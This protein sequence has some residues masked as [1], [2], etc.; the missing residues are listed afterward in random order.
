M[1]KAL[2]RGVIGGGSAT[3]NLNTYCIRQPELG[4]DIWWIYGIM[5]LTLIEEVPALS[6]PEPADA[7]L[8]S[9]RKHHAL[10]SHAEA[11]HDPAFTSGDPFFD[12]RDLVQVK[13]E[14]LRSVH[15]EGRPAS[16][17]A[18]DF[19]FSRPSFY[20]A[21]ALFEEGGLPALLPQRPGPKRAHKLSEEVVDFLEGAL[22]EDPSL[23]SARLGELLRGQLGL[24]VHPRSIERALERRSK[25]GPGRR[26]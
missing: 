1:P 18:Q 25:K 13:Y 19:G 21:Q 5:C 17:A 24:T 11:V 15:Q 7:K 8:Q 20:Q 14:M 23:N 26:P 12:A 22:T 3:A 2:T 10:N 9:L 16:R 4:V 6:K